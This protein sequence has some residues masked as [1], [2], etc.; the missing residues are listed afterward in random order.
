MQFFNKEVSSETLYEA[1]L[2]MVLD[3]D[4]YNVVLTPYSEKD[5]DAI[6]E[7]I[8]LYITQPFE[9][10]MRVIK[11]EKRRLIIGKEIEYGE[12]ASQFSSDMIF[13]NWKIS[14]DLQEPSERLKKLNA[15]FTAL[16]FRYRWCVASDL[17][18]FYISYL[19]QFIFTANEFLPTEN[20]DT[21]S[22]KL[23]RTVLRALQSLE[24][25]G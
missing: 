19:N 10:S 4:L 23:E 12:F 7:A 17:G 21:Q 22:L 1:C 5:R 6:A 15:C 18:V 8:F 20:R 2:R 14:D 3:S 25:L 13:E 11:L 16:C 9:R 24:G